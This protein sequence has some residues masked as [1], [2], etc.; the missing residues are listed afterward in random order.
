[1]L[2]AWARQCHT[3]QKT[4][5]HGE[6]RETQARA[7]SPEQLKGSDEL[8]S[9]GA[10]GSGSSQACQEKRSPREQFLDTQEFCA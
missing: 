3:V 9:L 1:M 7:V 2:S 6:R 8:L 10:C 5:T 4:T